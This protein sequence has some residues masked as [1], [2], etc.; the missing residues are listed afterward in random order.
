MR[1]NITTESCLNDSCNQNTSDI[2]EECADPLFS[3][4]NP[5]ICVDDDGNIVTILRLRVNPTSGETEVGKTYPFRAYLVFSDGREK[6]VTSM[7]TWTA[8]NDAVAT[9]EDTGVATG[10]TEGI[11]TIT[12][13]FRTY[14]AFA[15]LT[16]DAACEDGAVDFALVIDRSGSMQALGADG[17][18]RMEAA[19][20]ATLGFVRNVEYSTDQ[21]SVISF[22]GTLDEL[23]GTPSWESNVTVHTTLTNDQAGVESAV[24][25]IA[26]DFGQ[27][28][29]TDP[30]TGRR[31]MTCLTFI[32]T[33]LQAALD[34][35]T[36]SRAN[37][38]AKK[39][40]V[41]LTDGASNGLCSTHD[42]DTVAASIRA[43]N[44]IFAV[45]AL[46]VGDSE[47]TITCSGSVMS[48]KTWME[49]LTNCELFF[50]AETVDDLPNV[51]SRVPR[52]T[53]DLDGDPCFYAAP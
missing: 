17:K 5:S 37:P 4:D 35:L 40:V 45:I 36:S 26:P 28:V 47:L 52:I 25:A 12:A 44:M 29:Y 19:I 14:N 11:T 43:A 32:G 30:V 13:A 16:I 22:S 21:V 24:N 10:V 15:Q 53:C 51:F 8:G 9:V 6:D 46:A 7:S 41:L 18:S 50:D 49:S 48:V 1:F 42:P 27:C 2:P 33:G 39:C 38:S 23:D 34:E 31:R 3:A 20:E